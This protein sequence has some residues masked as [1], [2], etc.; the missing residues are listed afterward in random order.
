MKRWMVLFGFLATVCVGQEARLRVIIET[1]AGG[2]PDDEQSLVRFLVYANEFDIEGIIANRPVARD[3]ENKNP[4]RDGLVIVR[5]LVNAYGQC[6]T[7][8]MQHD[9]RFPKPEQLLARTVAGYD[10]T[11]DGV[12]LILRAVDAADPRPVWFC[13]WGTD[14]GSA[15]SC[16]KRALDRVRRERGLDSYGKFKGRLRLSSADK[17]SE[18]TLSLAPPFPLWVDTSR[19]TV[20]QK[21]WYHRFS[22][23]TA[24]A[25]GF[26]LERDV[27]TNHGPLGALYPPNTGLPQKEGD[28]MMFLYLIPTG[29]NDPN[30]PTWGSWAGRYGPNEECPGKPYFWANQTDAWHGTTN[31]DNTLARWAA[32]L[33]NDFRAHMDWCVKPRDAANHRPV[34]ALNGDTTRNILQI[35]VKSGQVVNLSASDSTDPDGD[36]LSTEWFVYHE[37]GTYRGEVSFRATNGPSTSFVSPAVK[38]A[39]TIHVILRI[40]DDGQPPLCSY[41]RVVVTVKP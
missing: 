36:A 33:Q 13:N 41:R 23:L 19:P 38:Q 26:D 24:Q 5:A 12:Q 37:A 3:R 34:G 7:N 29:M 6:Y 28:T 22:A 25:G 18:H 4:V 21:R 15:E 35:A 20:A 32:D 1:D 10:D 30:E 2:D 39:Q 16:L 9:P 8:L 14:H 11:D 17:F 40:S 27:R 31:R